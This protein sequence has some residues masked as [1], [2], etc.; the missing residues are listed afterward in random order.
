M[1][2]LTLP[3]VLIR[4]MT[5]EDLRGVMRIE[6]EQF[7]SPW[8]PLAFALELRHNGNAR[9]RIAQAGEDIVGYCGLWQSTREAYIMKIAVDPAYHQQ[10]LG[11]LLMGDMVAHAQNA[12]LESISL[13]VRVSN[14]TAISFYEHKG[15]VR[16]DVLTDY[17][18]KPREDAYLMR[19]NLQTPL[20]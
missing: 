15:F 11:N 12:L 19:R 6:I 13:D 20:S 9:Y 16:E 18:S 7:S 17:Y 4:A 5:E 8:T 1:K 3:A 10:G 14:T 2:G